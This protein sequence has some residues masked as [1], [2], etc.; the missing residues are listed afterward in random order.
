[1]F[2]CIVSLGSTA[3]LSC[4]RKSVSVSD[5]KNRYIFVDL[6]GSTRTGR[7]RRGAS[8][9]VGNKFC[10]WYWGYEANQVG[11]SMT[12]AKCDN[13]G[14]KCKAIE[15]NHRVLQWASKCDATTRDKHLEWASKRLAIAYIYVP[16]NWILTTAQHLKWR[17]RFRSLEDC[18]NESKHF[19]FLYLIHNFFNNYTHHTRTLQARIDISNGDLNRIILINLIIYVFIY[20]FIYLFICFRRL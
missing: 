3:P 15:M 1:M 11:G 10:P 16:S 5:L 2:L 7:T 12:V 8:P 20:L 19:C 13:C 17:T 14:P 6:Y 9:R 4:P 18:S